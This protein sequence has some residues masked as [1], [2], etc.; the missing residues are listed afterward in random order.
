MI[1]DSRSSHKCPDYHQVYFVAMTE[2]P[3]QVFALNE[4]TQKL[5][6]SYLIDTTTIL[7]QSKMTVVFKYILKNV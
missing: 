6:N 7:L 4:I 1:K 2:P 5:L 3:I